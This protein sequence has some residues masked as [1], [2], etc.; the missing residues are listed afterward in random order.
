MH[1]FAV[2][3]YDNAQV[4]LQFRDKHPGANPA[5]RLTLLLEW[6]LQSALAPF[7][8]QVGAL[9]KNLIF[10]ISCR[11]QPELRY[12]SV[13]RESK[14]PRRVETGIVSLSPKPCASSTA[15]S[16]SLRTGAARCRPRLRERPPWPKVGFRTAEG[17]NS[18]CS[19]GVMRQR[20]GLQLEHHLHLLGQRKRSMRLI[21]RDPSAAWRKLT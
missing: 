7:A 11:L 15:S 14:N 17:S 3:K 21:K 2:L 8:P 6:R 5:V 4:P 13:L 10:E 9:S 16:K 18:T 12:L 1:R 19:W 20:D